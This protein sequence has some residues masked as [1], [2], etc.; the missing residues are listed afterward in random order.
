MSERATLLLELGCEEIPA[1]MLPGAAADLGRIVAEVLDRAGIRH[2]EVETSW[3]PRRLVVRVRET[4]SASP[5]REELL[6]GPPA[7]AAWDAEGRPTRA[8]EGFARKHGATAAE[9]ERVET[10]RG[11][12]AALRVRRG[13]E[14]VGEILARELPGPVGRMSFPK[15][16][17]WG[18][19]RWRFVRPVHWIVALHGEEAHT[20]AFERARAT[21]E[22][23]ARL[24][25]PARLTSFP[26]VGHTIPPPLHRAW[27][28]VLER[29]VTGRL[30]PPP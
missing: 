21:V 22:H 27:L 9:L 20:V 25:W 12:Y 8:A 19:G 29:A 1:R 6:T 2:G 26:G 5:V 13:G 17:R 10:P 11:E 24:G 3:S 16:M 18:D 23:L 30:S 15:T 14:P 28:D 7:A 4:A